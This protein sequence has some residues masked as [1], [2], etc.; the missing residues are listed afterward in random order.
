MK[1]VPEQRERIGKSYL[2]Q[3]V[4]SPN[5]FSLKLISAIFYQIVIFSPNGSLLKT[6]KN[7]FYLI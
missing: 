5:L 6:M 4:A 3:N 2:N 1:K 7:V